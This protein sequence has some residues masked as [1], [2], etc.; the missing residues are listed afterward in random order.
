M[1]MIIFISLLVVLINNLN[2]KRIDIGQVR[3]LN[4]NNKKQN[5]IIKRFPQTSKFEL[6]SG[7]LVTK[8]N[9]VWDFLII[10]IT[11]ITVKERFLM[12]HDLELNKAIQQC[13]A[14]EELV[15]HVK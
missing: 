5:E 6:R 2:V 13:R 1:K 9:L 15:N 7:Y 8:K 12:E 10:G 14:K 3:F 11:D 4:C